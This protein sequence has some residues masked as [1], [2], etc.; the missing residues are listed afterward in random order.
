LTFYSADA[1]LLHPRA[2]INSTAVLVAFEMDEPQ[3]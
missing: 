1:G 2:C 3:K